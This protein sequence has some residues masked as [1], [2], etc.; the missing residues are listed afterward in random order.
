MKQ[1]YQKIKGLHFTRHDKDCVLVG[2]SDGHFIL[3]TETTNST[4]FFR[5]TDKGTFIEQ[6]FKDP[7]YRYHYIDENEL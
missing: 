7:K 2:Y 1:L 3:A 5:K 6:E 4:W